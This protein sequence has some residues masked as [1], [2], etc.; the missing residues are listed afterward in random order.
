MRATSHINER[1]M[2][3]LIISAENQ[4]EIDLLAKIRNSPVETMFLD[5]DGCFITP[6]SKAFTYSVLIANKES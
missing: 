5:V 3:A 1:G 4:E 6:T 2:A